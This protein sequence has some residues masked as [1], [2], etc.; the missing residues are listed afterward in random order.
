MKVKNFPSD[1]YENIS[2]WKEAYIKIVGEI[3]NFNFCPENLKSN[4][5]QLE[6][7]YTQLDGLHT[8]S[9]I[10]YELNVNNQTKMDDVRKIENLYDL[11]SEK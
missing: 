11:L 1:L 6:Y 10:Q 7:L 2:E 8:Y 4:I 5:I 9:L 3:N